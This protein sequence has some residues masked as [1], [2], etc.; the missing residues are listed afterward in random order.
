M[1]PHS[2]CRV[3]PDG[4]DELEVILSA[5]DRDAFGDEVLH[6]FHRRQNRCHVGACELFVLHEVADEGIVPGIGAPG[7]QQPGANRDFAAAGL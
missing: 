6:L 5:D 2:S 4:V 3:P 1:L 7:F